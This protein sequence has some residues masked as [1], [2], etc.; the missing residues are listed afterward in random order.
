LAPQAVISSRTLPSCTSKRKPPLIF[1]AVL[2]LPV[3]FAVAALAQVDQKVFPAPHFGAGSVWLD[4]G[5]PVPHHISGYPCHVV[6]IDFWEYT[7]INCIRDFRVLKRRYVKYHPYGFDY[8][9][10]RDPARSAHLISVQPEGS[11][12]TLHSFTYGN[13][14]QTG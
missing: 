7:C 6:L 14:C 1:V 3:C 9:L 2:A 5:A 12:L 4:Q 13:N 8:Y 11:V 10:V